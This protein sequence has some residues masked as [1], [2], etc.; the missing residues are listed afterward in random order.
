MTSLLREERI[1]TTEAKAKAVKPRVEKLIT[2]AINSLEA[3]RPAQV[4]AR[5][6]VLRDLTDRDV[7]FKLFDEIAPDLKG[8]PGGY[9][10]IV[11]LG[12]RR[13]DGAMMVILELVGE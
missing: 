7:L 12:P 9:T 4:A 2:R 6:E 5:R 11:R 1:T 10:R 3:E 13:G 8:R